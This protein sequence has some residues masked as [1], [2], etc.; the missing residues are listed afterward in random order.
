MSVM[1][2]AIRLSRDES[3]SCDNDMRGLRIMAPHLSFILADFGAN[4]T[5]N[6]VYCSTYAPVIDAIAVRS[7]PF[8]F[9]GS[10]LF[11]WSVYCLRLFQ[12]GI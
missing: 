1:L 3:G 4:T 7:C 8:L 6:C 12:N 11:L 10:S 5:R 2:T 9:P